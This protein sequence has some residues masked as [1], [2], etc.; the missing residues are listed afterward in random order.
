ML[1]DPKCRTATTGRKALR[2]LSDDRGLQPWVYAG[3]RRRLVFAG[4]N[5]DRPIGNN[6]MLFALYR[7]GCKGKMTGH[8]IRA[9]ASTVLNGQGW[10]ADA[11]ERQLAP[12][13]A[14]KC[15]APATVP[16]TCPS[17]PA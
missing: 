17:A 14:T 4:R 5:R 10:R 6:T 16:S 2:K 9:V 11:I 1:T 7:L 12:A 3:G 8:G 15:A 13:S